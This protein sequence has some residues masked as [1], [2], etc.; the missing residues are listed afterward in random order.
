MGSTD[1]PVI[2]PLLPKP[3]FRK[4]P[5]WRSAPPTATKPHRTLASTV[6]AHGNGTEVQ[7]T[8]ALIG[9][10]H[11]EITELKPKLQVVSRKVWFRSFCRW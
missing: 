7:S 4:S 11:Q 6:V 3:T 1:G 9:E 2:F 10:L 5:K 8:V